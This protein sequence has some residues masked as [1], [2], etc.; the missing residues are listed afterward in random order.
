MFYSPTVYW[1]DRWVF[2]PV[3][4]LLVCQLFMWVYALV[5]IHPTADQIFLHYSVVFGV[6]LIGEWWKILSAPFGG[7]LIF[8]VNFGVSW[9]FFGVDKILA[10]F[11]TIMAAL[12]NLFLV[13]ALYLVVGLNI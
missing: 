2:F 6:D 10:R 5:Y 8:L 3:I 13:I 9:Y 4:F 1:K 11:L 12:L 7:F